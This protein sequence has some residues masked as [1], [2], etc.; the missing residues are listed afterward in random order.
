MLAIAS[1]FALTLLQSGRAHA[2]GHWLVI[3]MSSKWLVMY[4]V[5]AKYGTI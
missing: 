4:G 5:P 3:D 2:I 1:S